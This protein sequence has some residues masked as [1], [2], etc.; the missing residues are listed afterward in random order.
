MSDWKSCRFVRSGLSPQAHSYINASDLKALRRCRGFADNYFCVRNIEHLVLA[1][2]EEVMVRRDV[3]IKIGFR[4][5][6]CDLSQQANFGE[7]MQSV[8]DCRE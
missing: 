1:F 5:I 7:L 8:V 3:G 4:A 2:N 6:N